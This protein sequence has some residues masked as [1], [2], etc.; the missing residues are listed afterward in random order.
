[1]CRFEELRN[2]RIAKY[3]GMNLYV[4]NLHD[5]VDDETLRSEFAAVRVWCGGG[6]VV[7]FGGI[8]L[9][10]CSVR[11]GLAGS[12]RAPG[13]GLGG[14]AAYQQAKRNDGAGRQK[15]P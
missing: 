15:A 12:R 5:D 4:K 11:A 6:K 2:E 7:S 3:Q 8:L 13:K 1:M 10:A 9:C 14:C